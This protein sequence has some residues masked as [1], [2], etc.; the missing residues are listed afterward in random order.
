MQEFHSEERLKDMKFRYEH[1]RNREGKYLATRAIGITKDGHV[2][3]MEAR[4]NPKDTFN[5][6]IGREVAMGKAKK[7]LSRALKYLPKD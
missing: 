6:K 2:V 5:K 4:L 1:I 3:V 7:A